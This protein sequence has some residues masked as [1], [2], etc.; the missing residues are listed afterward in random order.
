MTFPQ[1]RKN[2]AA[3]CE[4]L[5]IETGAD[6]R[7]QE[8]DLKV[9]SLCFWTDDR[10]ITIAGTD[11]NRASRL[12][13]QDL[14]PEEGR[15]NYSTQSYISCDRTFS[16]RFTEFFAEMLEHEPGTGVHPLLDAARTATMVEIFWK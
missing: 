2:V 10:S 1:F 7:V 8:K 16:D 6:N 11:M 15:Q 12:F 3:L 13:F 9:M 5:G 14:V 4:R